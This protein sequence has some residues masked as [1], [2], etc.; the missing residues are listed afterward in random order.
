VAN[1][2]TIL[3][4]FW[5]SHRNN[6]YRNKFDSSECTGIVRTKFPPKKLHQIRSM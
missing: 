6:A 3:V 5:Y 2:L 1:Q 4:L